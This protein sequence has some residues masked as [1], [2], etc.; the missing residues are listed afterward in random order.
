MT[1]IR[2]S[3]QWPPTPSVLWKVMAAILI[4]LL[5]FDATGTRCAGQSESVGRSLDG[6]GPFLQARAHGIEPRR[7]VIVAAEHVA[8]GMPSD[9]LRYGVVTEFH[10][11]AQAS[12]AQIVS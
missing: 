12:A 11:A 1:P 3:R 6:L 9:T 5:V 4:H 2:V 7:S 10:K 8:R